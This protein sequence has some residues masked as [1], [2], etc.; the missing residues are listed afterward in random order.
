MKI[1][2][3]G[4]IEPEVGDIVVD[5]VSQKRLI[6]SKGHKCDECE[7]RQECMQALIACKKCER[8][9]NED[10]VFKELKD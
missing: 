10:I 6:V 3:K 4:Y 9:D 8:D 1:N 5:T 2:S 7:Y